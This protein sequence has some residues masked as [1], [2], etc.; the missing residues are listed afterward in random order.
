MQLKSSVHTGPH[1]T[2]TLQMRTRRHAEDS[3]KAEPHLCIRG[4]I[5]STCPVD[6][7]RAA[8]GSFYHMPFLPH[9]LGYPLVLLTHQGSSLKA[10]R[11]PSREERDLEFQPRPP[12]PTLAAPY[13][14]SL[15]SHASV[16]MGAALFQ[17]RAAASAVMAGESKWEPTRERRPQRQ[18]DSQRSIE[19]ICRE[20]GHQTQVGL[21][22]V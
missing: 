1:L 21:L 12:S 14:N 11:K 19:L 18:T 2:I 4:H 9:Q 3:A 22:P 17:G 16:L 10:P 15:P 13:E 8:V 5:G 6:S 20:A 7:P